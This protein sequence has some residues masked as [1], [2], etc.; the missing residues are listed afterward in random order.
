MS[1]QKPGFLKNHAD[2][3]A[4]IGVNVAIMAIIIS[5]WFSNGSSIATICTRMDIENVAF[6][7]RMDAFTSR[8]DAANARMDKMHDMFYDLLR[9]GKKK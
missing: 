6:N 4:I 8:M 5:L 3:L 2:T 9:E 7:S 1:E